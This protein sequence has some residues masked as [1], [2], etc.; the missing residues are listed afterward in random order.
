[1][2]RI[3]PAILLI[4]VLA[5]GGG[6]IATTA[7]QAGLQTAVTTTAVTDGT[8]ATVV[9]PAYG[10]GYGW[11]PFGFGFGFLG[12]LG[13]LLFFFLVFGLIRAIF[14]GGRHRHWDGPGWGPG[15]PTGSS[16]PGAGRP[17]GSRYERW[18]AVL[19]QDFDEWHRGAHGPA[20]GPSGTG[21]D[22]GGTGTTPPAPAG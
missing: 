21:A 9:V 8:S 18:E 4:A 15:G 10:V 12:F 6:I 11:H 14:W 2:R 19:H 17:Y 16:G 20:S 22:A 13:A 3:I 7:Y 5:I 1:M